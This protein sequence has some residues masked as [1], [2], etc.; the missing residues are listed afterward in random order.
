MAWGFSVEKATTDDAQEVADLVIKLLREINHDLLE[1]QSE[2][3]IANY[4][5][6]L[7]GDGNIIAFIAY[8]DKSEPVGVV[9]LHECASVYAG[10]IFGELSELYVEPAYRSG[11]VGHGLLNVA[12]KYGRERGWKRLAVGLPDA[13]QWN[14][15]YEFYKS[16]GFVET[17]PKLKLP[18]K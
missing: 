18:L 14:R 3:D 13:N 16:C 12:V 5:R 15:T 1:Q 11:T 7:I 17:G 4:T 6:E 8:N 9:T 2:Q 10:G